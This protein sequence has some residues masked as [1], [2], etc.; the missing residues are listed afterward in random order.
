MITNGRTG[1]R[2]AI[3]MV[4]PLA[5]VLFAA[6]LATSAFSAET[7]QVTLSDQG[8]AADMPTGLGMAMPGA[9]MAKATMKIAASPPTVQGG[10]V[11]FE[12]TNASKELVHEMLVVAVGS[13]PQPL[14]YDTNNSG[15]DEKV[16][17]SLGEVEERDPGATGSLTLDL[18][19]G[20]Y[21]LFC[22]VPGHYAA[23][24]WAML[25]VVPK[26][27]LTQ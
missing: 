8:A 16:A 13:T 11:T 10:T 7:V 12:V 4:A 17:G 5:A 22:N 26:P 23:G 27:Q 1:F 19:P 15:V 25:T 3:R 24:M 20:K 21:I 18:K 14:P 6:S 9:E 2:N